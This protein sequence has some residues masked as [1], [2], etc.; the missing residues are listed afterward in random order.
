LLAAS[1]AFRR[2]WGGGDE[3]SADGAAV[4]SDG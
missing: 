2:L 4:A 3:A 1:E